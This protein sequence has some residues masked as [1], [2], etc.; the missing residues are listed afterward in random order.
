MDTVDING[1]VFS[2]YLCLGSCAV[3]ICPTD[4]Q[5][6]VLTKATKP[7]KQYTQRKLSTEQF[8]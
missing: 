5:S 1:N 2:I 6:V 7:A 3:F 4:V 8:S